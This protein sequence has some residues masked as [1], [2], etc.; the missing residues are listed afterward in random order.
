[1]LL[2]PLLFS[3]AIETTQ[4]ITGLGITE[5]DDVFGNTLGGWIG[6]L[7]AC[8]ALRTKWKKLEGEGFQK[9][10]G[11]PFGKTKCYIYSEQS[12]T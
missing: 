2:I 5:F 4:Y 6:I 7:T 10:S 8:T 11:K 3:I 12:L 9:E 1:M